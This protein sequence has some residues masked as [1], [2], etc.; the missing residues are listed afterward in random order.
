MN[1]KFSADVSF[2]HGE[3]APNLKFVGVFCCSLLCFLLLKI[4]LVYCLIE[5]MKGREVS[6]N[7]IYYK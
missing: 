3:N 5:C 4:Y 6:L 7:V 1:I 2:N